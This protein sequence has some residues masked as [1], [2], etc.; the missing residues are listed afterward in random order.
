MRVGLFAVGLFALG[1]G[2]SA[3]PPVKLA[4]PAE[5]RNEGVP[6]FPTAPAPATSDP[7][8]A[9]TAVKILA[10]HTSNDPSVVEKLKSVFVVRT[11][12]KLPGP[13]EA[14][15]ELPIRFEF[16]AVWPNTYKYVFGPAV[17]IGF[18]LL[19]ADGRSIRAPDQLLLSEIEAATFHRDAFGEWLLLAV[20]LAD[21]KAVF[22]PGPEMTVDGKKYPGLRLW[23]P[24]A[25]QVILSYDPES[26][27]V[28][29]WTYN[30][31]SVSGVD[32]Q[33]ELITSKYEATNGLYYPQTVDV[34]HAGMPMITFTKA[35]VEFPKV[36]D[37][38]TFTLPKN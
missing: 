26:F 32:A 11:G 21:P 1:C 24:D 6:V 35:I 4:K 31:L 12:V 16:T 33:I 13:G 5:Q 34:R 28:V 17:G 27:R 36:F 10:A 14:G 15:G 20:P 30:G 3:G 2:G 8:A 37:K 19:R 25:P 7:A 18:T 29:K 22:A 38:N 23:M 9:A